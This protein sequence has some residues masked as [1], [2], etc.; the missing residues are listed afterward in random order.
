MDAAL[1]V[2]GPEDAPYFE[3]LHPKLEMAMRRMISVG[4]AVPVEVGGEEFANITSRGRLA[5]QCF[6]AVN[7][8]MP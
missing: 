4:N 5:L 7:V 8:R 6:A 2:P 1:P 3:Q